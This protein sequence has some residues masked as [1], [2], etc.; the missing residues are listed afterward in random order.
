MSEEDLP[1]QNKR[2]IIVAALVSLVIVVLVAVL[3]VCLMNS[4]SDGVTD[5]NATLVEDNNSETESVAIDDVNANNE[6][7]DATENISIV[8]ERASGDL[9]QYDVDG[10]TCWVVDGTSAA[11][12]IATGVP[13]LI[14][15]HEGNVDN[16]DEWTLC[17]VNPNADTTEEVWIDATDVLINLPDVNSDIWYDITYSYSSALQIHGLDVPGIT[18]EQLTGYSDG[19]VVNERL[20]GD[21][22]FVV[23]VYWSAAWRLDNASTQAMA[24]N[25]RF[26]V[27][28][29][30]RP[31]DA[32]KQMADAVAEFVSENNVT[33]GSWSSS[34]FVSTGVSA[35]NTGNALDIYI[36]DATLSEDE[37]EADMLENYPTAIDECSEWSAY[38][39]SPNSSTVSEKMSN[40]R[41]VTILHELMT[42]AGFRQLNS[43]W[44][45]FVYDDGYDYVMSATGNTGLN[46][47]ATEVVSIIPDEE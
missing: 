22:E 3:S 38:T 20:N 36:V 13:L 14:V 35:H 15:D 31:Y 28:D 47:Y 25:Y 19:E 27:Y 6:A 29:A 18:G 30:Y 21:T 24:Y 2:E 39:V 11:E 43:E 7:D 45:H 46:F 40:S 12:T 44:W 32:T 23:P 34:Y 8:A 42:S 26:V 17:V 5:G 1:L 16:P 4:S 37:I 9:F 33:F 10:A 41:Y